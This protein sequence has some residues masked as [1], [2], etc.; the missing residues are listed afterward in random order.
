MKSL[1]KIIVL[2]LTLI[3]CMSAVACSS[4]GKVEKALF[5][6]GFEKI[7]TD[8]IVESIKSESEIAVKTH[9]FSNEKNLSALEYL[10]ITM[11]IVFEF[12]ATEQM[13][14]FYDDSATMQ[15]LLEDIKEDGTAENFYNDLVEQGLANGNCLIICLNPLV[16]EEVTTAI[17]NA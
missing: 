16:F 17:K 11:V 14:E 8:D 5:S 12:K 10:K 15:G 13:K 2:A 3:V 7:E 6:V 9:V 1:R 4:Y